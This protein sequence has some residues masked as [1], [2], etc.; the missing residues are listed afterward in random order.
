M[1]YSMGCTADV[2]HYLGEIGGAYVMLGR[3]KKC[4]QGSV[5]ET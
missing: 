3:E 2:K 1:C 4:V 5:V